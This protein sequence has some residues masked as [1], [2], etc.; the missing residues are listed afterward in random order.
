VITATTIDRK[1]A[2]TN[3][4]NARSGGKRCDE[5]VELSGINKSNLKQLPRDIQTQIDNLLGTGRGVVIV[6]KI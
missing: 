5:F 4:S 2:T 1:Q 3:V 6:R